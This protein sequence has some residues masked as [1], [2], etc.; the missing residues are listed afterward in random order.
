MSSMTELQ[1]TLKLHN[2]R[3]F[4][5]LLKAGYNDLEGDFHW[6]TIKA[7]SKVKIVGGRSQ[8]VHE[9]YPA[10]IVSVGDLTDFSGSI[11]HLKAWGAQFES[12]I[13]TDQSVL[14]IQHHAEFEDDAI[15]MAEHTRTLLFAAKQAGDLGRRCIFGLQNLS[16]SAPQAAFPGSKRDDR[17]VSVVE[18]A[19]MTVSRQLTT[20]SSDNP[21]WNEIE[22]ITADGST[23][24]GGGGSTIPPT[25][26]GGTGGGGTG[27]GGTGG[28]GTATVPLPGSDG[29]WVAPP[30]QPVAHAGPASIMRV[31]R[32]RSGRIL[33][34][35]NKN[36]Q[37]VLIYGFTLHAPGGD[38]EIS[39][40]RDRSDRTLICLDPPRTYHPLQKLKLSYAPG[41]VQ[42]S[43]RSGVPLN[44]TAFGPVD[45]S[46]AP[47][48]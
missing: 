31:E 13:Y 44:L 22:V 9:T 38:V 1:P 24:L 27:G 43:P 3:T 41:N 23:V 8:E 2:E 5:A 11:D 33:V 35:L 19:F 4:V 32:V 16:V 25:G 18:G 14:R 12:R 29:E 42:I 40:F 21:I 26:G 36:I 15:R 34:R 17:F 7:E 46:P 39:G 45:V 48:S 6:D 30:F 20:P 47:R 37:T 10:I 28:G